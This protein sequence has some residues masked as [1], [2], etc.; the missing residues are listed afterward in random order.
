MHGTIGRYETPDALDGKRVSMMRH[1]LILAYDFPPRGATS[2]LRIAKFVRYLP[3][4]G[5]Q[6]VVVTATVRGGLRD[7]A[8][9]AQLPPNLEVIHV[10]NPFAPA[11]AES[12]AHSAAPTR[13]ARLRQQI[14]QLI[15]PDPQILWVP[16]VVR[17]MAKRIDRGN[18]DA[19]MSTAPPFSVHVAALWLKCGFP[20]VPWL[21]D[22]RDIWSEHPT[23]HNLLLY[24]LQR[25]CEGACLDAADH[26]TTATAG[27]RWLLREAFDLPRERI[28]T[29][30]NGFDPH[31]VPSELAPPPVGPLRLAHLGS[32][33]GARAEAMQGFFAALRQ[34]LAAG[35]TAD[36]LQVRLV[37]IHGASIYKWAEPLVAAGIVQ[38]LPFMSYVDAFA[39]MT[40]AHVLLLVTS[41]D[42]EGRL[43]HP[44][45]LFEYFALGKPMLA[46]TPPG[47]VARLVAEAGVGVTVPPRE[48]EQIAAAL[49]TLVE[50][51]RAG[52][53]PQF[54]PNDPRFRRFERRNLTQQLATLLD[55]LV[56]DDS[57]QNEI[58]GQ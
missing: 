3:E 15:V 55:S 52:A 6:P 33:I 23:I 53:L 35:L 48:P 57:R 24:K 21:M 2:V 39:E 29:I 17:A 14:R 40:A 13:S 26:V 12:S 34:L 7:E 4:F 43:S 16:A 54:T 36:D 10:D 38:L 19:L 37:G 9:L 8:L 5:W 50:Q 58:S 51:H 11:S 41:D 28:S 18:I 42:R 46:V 45:K 32:L 1:V 20:Q 49:Q 22:L 27:Q 56:Q 31:D 47:D 25:W 44:N 30:T